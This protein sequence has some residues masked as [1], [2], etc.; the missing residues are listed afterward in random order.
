MKTNFYGPLLTILIGLLVLSIGMNLVF[1]QR[2]D[3]LNKTISHT[4]SPVSE[5]ELKEYEKEIDR[6]SN[7]QYDIKTKKPIK[8]DLINN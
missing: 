5:E 1:Y 3:N 7:I 2:I 6:L 4:T 8:N